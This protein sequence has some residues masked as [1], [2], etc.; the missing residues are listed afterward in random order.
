MRIAITIDTDN[1]AFEDNPD[2]EIG[3]ILR[4]LAGQIE[5]NGGTVAGDSWALLD[6]NGNKVG[7]CEA[8]ESG[9]VSADELA[10]TIASLLQD[11]PKPPKSIKHPYT[12]TYNLARATLNRYRVG[13]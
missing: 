1:A 5:H 12:F 8:S 11:A 4:K 2:Y 6:S 7:K 10:D 9:K 3:R 13:A